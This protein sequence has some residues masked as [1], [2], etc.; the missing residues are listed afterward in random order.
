MGFRG[1]SVCPESAERGS[2]GKTSDEHGQ[3]PGFAGSWLSI[4]C[5]FFTPSILPFLATTPLSQRSPRFML[6]MALCKVK[7]TWSHLLF[8]SSLCLPTLM[9]Q[10]IA[11]GYCSSAV[12]M[13]LS[14][15]LN[16]KCAEPGPQLQL[17]FTKQVILGNWNK[18]H[19]LLSGFFHSSFEGFPAHS[20][21]SLKLLSKW[22]AE[23]HPVLAFLGGISL[24]GG[25]LHSGERML[26]KRAPRVLHKAFLDMKRLSTSS[27]LCAPASVY[28]FSEHPSSPQPTRKNCAAVYQ[29]SLFKVQIPLSQT[30]RNSRLFSEWLR[31]CENYFG[32]LATQ[33]TYR[34]SSR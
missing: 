15:S 10:V 20:S 26:R 24:H 22:V 25:T 19:T 29:I 28:R 27:V 12:L 33:T 2:D 23:R 6:S 1:S 5:C 3:P 30:W 7:D 32:H 21:L 17:A 9:F 8:L 14:Y 13:I 18:D 34:F 4:T 11:R 16:P 31:Y